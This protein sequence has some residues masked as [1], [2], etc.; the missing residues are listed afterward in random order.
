[1]AM[2]AGIS[3]PRQSAIDLAHCARPI[4]AVDARNRYGRRY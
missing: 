3:N 2:A 1:M 4:T